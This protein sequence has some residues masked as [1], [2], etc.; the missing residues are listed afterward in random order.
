MGKIKD[1][2]AREIL[3]SRGNPTVE[4]DVFLENGVSG[5]A[6]VPSGASTGKFEAL[7]LRD[8]DS[9]RF[10]G[11]GVQRAVEN[12]NQK[13]APKLIGLNPQNQKEIDNLLLKLDGTENKE[14]MGANALL[15]VSMAVSKASSSLLGIPLFKYLGGEGASTLP[16]PLLNILN[17]GKHA[18]NNVDIQEF[19][20]VPAGAKSFSESLQVGAETYHALK[21]V[22]KEKGLSTSVGDEGG[23]APN[24]KS[25]EEA[26][27]VIIEA[28]KRAGYEP[29][30]D[31]SLA[32]D[33][34]ATE[35]FKEGKYVLAGEK[36]ELSSGEM[37]KYLADLVKK[38]PIISI[39]DGLDEE[40]WEGWRELTEKL[41]EIIQIV[42]DDIFVTNPVRL[43]RGIEEKVANAIL[44]K[45]NQIGT[46]T[47]T[48]ETI[49]IAVKA[50][51]RV[52]ISHRSGETG[53]NF[54]SDLAV[55]VNSG[56]IKTGAPARSD[57]VSKYNQL[58]RIEEALGEKA[59]YL[60]F[61]SF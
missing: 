27:E 4:V 37:V 36:K 8:G 10:S 26:L 28:I 32:L 60:G 2:I 42:G 46:L 61:K 13:I 24:L 45:L 7:E 41:G 3:D 35:L 57:R 59:K 14:N 47:E 44:I 17:G 55:A 50:G 54:I 51:Y 53:D 6:A 25:N 16:V 5:R 39:E 12:V 34:A 11:K 33:V 49:D 58:L 30:K 29:G 20:I 31:I 43:N 38:Y 22:L 15:G 48:L 9:K 40:D 23:F 1:I 21:K 19:M 52:V 56:Q 18:D